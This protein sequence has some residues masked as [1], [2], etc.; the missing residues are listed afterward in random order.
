MSCVDSK[1]C[2]VHFGFLWDISNVDFRQSS[3]SASSMSSGSE[4][5]ISSS[6]ELQQDRKRATREEESVG[7]C[8]DHL[9][10]YLP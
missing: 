6:Y 9:V 8:H 7:F 4:A 2:L 10:N 3:L 1:R 5:N